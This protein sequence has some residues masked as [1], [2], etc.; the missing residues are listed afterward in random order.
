MESNSFYFDPSASQHGNMFFLG[1]LNPGGARSMMMINIEETSKRRPFFSSPEDLYDEEYYDDQLPEKKRRLTSEQVHLLE[2]SFETEN[3]LE[4]E[5]KTQLAK[6]L[7]LQP[8][9]VAV[10][11]Q[12]RRARWKTKQLERDYDLLKSTYDQ[13][14]SNYDSIVKDNDKLRSEVT[15]LTEK[16]LGN[17]E[18]ANNELTP[19]R[20]VPEL[21]QLDPVYLNPAAIKTE[22]RLSS[23]SVGSAVL[24]ED[25]PQLL[26]SCD[27][28]FP[29]LVP[30]HSQQD[31]NACDNDRACF[32]DVFVPTTSPSHHH[33]ESLGFWAWP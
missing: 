2:K 28:Y 8:R 27:S 18:E 32:S 17:E 1:N 6:K 13:L 12:N 24:D 33:G 26:D 10:W 30:I 4:P 23:G 5:R 14:L 3:K 22:D 25:A 7:G 11:F 29:S 16:L 9:Q 19:G 20:Q 21:N 15:S 31:N